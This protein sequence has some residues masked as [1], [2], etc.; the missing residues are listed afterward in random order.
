MPRRDIEAMAQVLIEEH[1][2]QERQESKAQ[3]KA[4][5]QGGG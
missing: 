1:Q 5:R 2:E 3:A 4:R